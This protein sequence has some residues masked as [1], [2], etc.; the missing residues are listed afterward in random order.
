MVELS[1]SHVLVV[2]ATGVLGA[3]LSRQL[4]AQGAELTLSGRS[5]EKLSKLADELG[6]AV[7][8]QVAADL[9]KPSGP[10]DIAAA[11]YG[12]ELNG[13]V[14]ASGVVAFGPAVE[15]DDDTLDELM[16]V[17]LLGYMRLMRDVAPRLPRDSFV[18][19]ISAVVAESPTAGMAAY[20]ASKAGLSA[21]GA[22][23]TLELRRQGVRVLDARPP[24]T[25][26]GLAARPIAGEAPRLPQGKD[27][28][29]VAG[30][31][32]AAI[33]E[34]ERDLPSSSF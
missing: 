8:G 7:V 19:Q 29:A 16:L 18:A 26:T 25:E 1:G 17:N 11:V 5:R 28:V 6:D 27:P 33:R 21:Y 34:G 23:L 13:V 4:A 12:R 10:A 31:I 3:E 24:H 2:G 22:A 15:V 14:F 20:S 30:R 9:G 32:V